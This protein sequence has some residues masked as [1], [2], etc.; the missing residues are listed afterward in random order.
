MNLQI[1]IL[2]SSISIQMFYCETYIYTMHMYTNSSL[3]G[4]VKEQHEE[5]RKENHDFVYMVYVCYVCYVMN[6]NRAW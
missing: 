2:F 5:E 4:L 1:S 6:I 3:K